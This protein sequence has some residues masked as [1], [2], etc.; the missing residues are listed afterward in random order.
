MKPNLVLITLASC[1][2]GNLSA[3]G[4]VTKFFPDKERDYQHTKEIPMLNWPKDLRTSPAVP[5]PEQIS[6][7]S[8][9][10]PTPPSSPEAASALESSDKTVPATAPTYENI[11]PA[12][13]PPY[14]ITADLPAQAKPPSDADPVPD[15][16]GD[17][18]KPLVIEQVKRDGSSRL[19]LYGSMLRAWRAI[20][21]AL[22]RNSVEVTKRNPEEHRYTVQYDPDE[23]K[24]HDGSFK[25]EITFIF[26]GFQ[27]HEQEYHLQLIENSDHIEMLIT[28]NKQK[29]LADTAA[30]VKLLDVLEKA[31]KTESTDK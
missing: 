13:A 14:D 17:T 16:T 25:D 29:P 20:D 1:I 15:D 10:V 21:K 23:K 26:K 6:P 4:H 24:A 9:S 8:T 12:T 30:S 31:I 3:C 5:A 22:S 27:T 7:L 28:D 11:D 19:R 18:T 2:L